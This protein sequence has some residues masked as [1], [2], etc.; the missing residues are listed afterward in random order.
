AYTFGL[1]GPAVVVDTACSSSLV[2]VHQACQSLRAGE[3]NLA[4]TGGVNLILFDNWAPTPDDRMN[5]P[6]GR[7]KTFDAAA[8]GFGRGEGCGVVV[9]KR[10]SDALADGDP[11]LAVIRGSAVNQDGRSSGLSAPS[12]PSQQEV[13]Q[14]ALRNAG[15][16]PAQ[17]GYI[18]A[19]GTGTT[20]G[21]PIEIGAINALFG[22][23][24]DPL[25]VGSVKTNFGHL[26]GAAGIAG[27]IKLVLSLHHGEIAPHLHFQHPNPYIDW[28]DSPVQVPTERTPWPGNERIGG[29][30]SFGISGTNAHIVLAAAP[31]AAGETDARTSTESQRSHHLLTLSAKNEAAL[32]ELARVYQHY[33][34]TQPDTALNA[35]AQ[36]THATRSHFAQRLSVVGDTAVAFQTKLAAYADGQNPE[37]SSYGY[38][39]NPRSRPQIAFLFTGQG[40]Q[41]VGMG[42][43]LYASEPVFRGIVDRCERVAQVHLRR[44]LLDLF[45]P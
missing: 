23:R 21:D 22:K 37:Q 12:G 16:K 44:S 29:I 45:Y 33:L 34:A 25:W 1:R 10:L 31:Q 15:V 13:I 40:S 27:L 11:I 41:Y 35:I 28:E 14:Q 32:Q 36:A 19:H 6:D 24:A 20:L 38:A 9:L 17:V 39:P 30:S 5:A 42:R 43:D 7:C 18:E 3:C 2:A 26:E 8:D 4:L